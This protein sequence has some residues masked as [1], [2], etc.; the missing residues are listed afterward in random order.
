MK[1]RETSPWDVDPCVCVGPVPT[2]VDSDVVIC[3]V[4]SSLTFIFVVSCVETAVVSEEVELV[5]VG[6]EAVRDQVVSNVW[7]A[8]VEVNKVTTVGEGLVSVVTGEVGV[9]FD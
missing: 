6:N 1:N 9:G 5:I 7:L 3:F 4:V 8:S 2:V